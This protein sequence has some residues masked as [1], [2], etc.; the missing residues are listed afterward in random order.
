M[1][2]KY[3]VECHCSHTLR[4]LSPNEIKNIE[5]GRTKKRKM[6]KY[7]FLGFFFQII[8]IFGMITFSY[9]II[10]YNGLPVMSKILIISGLLQ[11]WLCFVISSDFYDGSEKIKENGGKK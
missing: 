7:L 4:K 1:R 3:V 5:I 10:F 11:T 9:G 8:G 2:N 6:F